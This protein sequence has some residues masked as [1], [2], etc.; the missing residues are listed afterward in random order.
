MDGKRIG[1]DEIQPLLAEAAGG[2]VVQEV[3]LDYLLESELAR[4]R[5]SVSERDIAAERELLAQ[6]VVREAQAS[7]A[8]AERLLESVRRSRGLGELRF[9]AL[10]RR[11]AGMRKIVAPDVGVSEEELRQAYEIR[12]G[13]RFRVRVILVSSQSEAARLREGDT[14]PRHFSVFPLNAGD[15]RVKRRHADLPLP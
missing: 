12:H 1:W 9:A 7:T 15:Q 8:D 11:N 4:R 3:A 13:E 14:Q 2:E 5:L 10:L 6:A